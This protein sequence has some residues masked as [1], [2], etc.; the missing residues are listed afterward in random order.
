VLPNHLEGIR[1]IALQQLLSVH[2]SV[3]LKESMLQLGKHGRSLVRAVEH[4]GAYT[5]ARAAELGWEA[6]TASLSALDDELKARV[7]A[8]EAGLS[9]AEW[10]PDGAERVDVCGGY[11]VA[12][13]LRGHVFDVHAAVEHFLTGAQQLPEADLSERGG[14]EGTELA[15][16]LERYSDASLKAAQRVVTL[17]ADL[18]DVVDQQRERTQPLCAT[19]L[20]KAREAHKRDRIA[21]HLRA[22]VKR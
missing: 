22:Q 10:G 16:P 11:A 19:N 18:L 1:R 6:T 3:L 21:K 15:A 5:Q 17:L 12:C 13:R 20:R 4:D 8:I 14:G 2:R 9:T 7:A